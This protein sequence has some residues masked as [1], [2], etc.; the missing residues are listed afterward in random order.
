M[1]TERRLNRFLNAN[2]DGTSYKMKPEEEWLHATSWRKSRMAASRAGWHGNPQEQGQW[3]YRP[4]M[5]ENN[6][7]VQYR[8]KGKQGS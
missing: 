2:R 5:N 1:S 4:E 8:F 7:K 3:E 6:P